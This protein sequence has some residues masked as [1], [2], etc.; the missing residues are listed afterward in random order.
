MTM[1][2]T[3]LLAL[4]AIMLSPALPAQVL[5][6]GFL[7]VQVQG[8]WLS[9]LQVD[10]TGKGKYLPSCWL[11]LTAGDEAVLNIPPTGAGRVQ[12]NRLTWRGATLLVPR[13]VLASAERK[14]ALRLEPGHTLAQEFTLDTAGLTAVEVNCPT[15]YTAN[16][17]MTL[18]LWRYEDGSWRR[19]ASQRFSNVQDNGWVRLVVSPQ[20]AG[21]Y[22]VEMSEPVGTIGWWSTHD[23]RL[24]QSLPLRDGHPVDEGERCVRLMLFDTRPVD[25]VYTLTRNRL[26]IAVQSGE[27]KQWVL[28]TPWKAEGTDT[29][30]PERVLF[31]R[32][33]SDTGRYLPVE[34][35]KR[36]D[37]LEWGM[38]A[39][40][41]LEMT[42]NGTADYRWR[43]LNGELRW[44]MTADR[45]RLSLHTGNSLTLEILPHNERRLPDFYPVFF[46]S[47]SRLDRLINRFYYERAFSWPLSPGL[48]DWME[49]LAR[50]RYWV[51]LPGLHARE[52]A[53]LLHYRI[54]EDGYVYT[55]GDRK[56]WPFPDND[57]YDARHFT[58]NANFIL[59][60]WRYY[61][62]TG[63]KQFLIRNIGRIRHAMEW[64]LNE[65]RGAEGLF[66][67]NSPDHDGTSKGVHSNYWDDIP[68]G[69]LS[70]YENIYFYASLH[71]MAEIESVV[72]D[73]VPT[74][75]PA[76]RPPGYYRQL[77]QTVKRRY[78]ETF[79]NDTAGRYIGCVDI[80]GNRHDYGFTY[81]NTEALAYGLGDPVK[82]R[83]IYHWMEHEPTA[84]GKPDTY[85]F[86]FAPRVNTLDCSGWWY[87]EG[88]AEIPSQ[89][90]DTH[91]ENGGAILYTSFFDLMARH[92]WLGADNAYGRLWGILRRYDQPDRLCGGNPLY[93]GGKPYINGWAVGTDIPFP[94]SGLVPTFFLYGFLGVDARVDGLHIAPLLPRS[95]SFAGV[96][97]LFYRGL[98]LDLRVQRDSGGYGITLACHQPGYRFILRQ[99]VK[100]GEEWVFRQPPAPLRFP[101][102]EV[103]LGADWQAEWIWLPGQ[104]ETPNLTVYARRGIDLP[105]RPAEA[106][107]WIT[108]DNRYRLWINGTPVGEDTDFRRAERYDVTRLLRAG[109]N[110]IAVQAE[111]GDGPGG[112][113]VEM[114]LRLPNGR[115]LWVISDANWKVTAQAEGNWRA[116][117][118]DDRGWQK[119]ESRGR[120]PVF[121][122][123]VIER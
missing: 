35:L 33:F 20:P 50:T 112:L 85:F 95:L 30:D 36:R 59:A 68:F 11:G 39:H 63:D 61:C 66:V 10:P 2:L 3:V 90:F 80:H 67:D 5:E 17:G 27:V 57:K 19:V 71:A 73:V 107:L 123:G 105:A 98:K 46:S 100:E 6:N 31:R 116:P 119:A 106:V 96:R 49:W 64:Q 114:R 32:F 51:A 40:D 8:G 81:V 29:T 115:T 118:A 89:P 86:E 38:D 97:N 69:H 7:R 121:P 82:A 18:S 52:R 25:V 53:H 47:D 104:W 41:W 22:R 122:W 23:K 44:Q 54:D 84:T 108:A 91:C 83:R 74:G 37:G 21:R 70:A 43:N 78:A 94:E 14:E 109:K 120:A 113:L 103:L 15:W 48:A 77:A 75:S 117:D 62:W 12:G 55:W 56:E 93:F 60:C 88:K 28:L 45:M 26:Q 102:L 13:A 92:R 9:E 4:T 34:Q 42:G 58:T 111:N 110:V 79:W 16:S 72:G 99:R 65:C 76:P 87:L 101:P 1:R 24:P